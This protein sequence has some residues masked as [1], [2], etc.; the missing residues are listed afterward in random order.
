MIEG[1]W[2]QPGDFPETVSN[3]RMSVFGSGKD[4][5]DEK[6]WNVVVLEDGFPA[7]TGRI[8]WQ[9]GAFRLGCISV[10]PERRGHLLGDLVLRLLLYKAESHAAREVRLISPE[11]TVGFFERLGFKSVTSCKGGTEMLLPGDRINLDRCASCNK[12]GCPRRSI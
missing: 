5:L 6:S 8:W 9:E 7:A 4:D 12:T 10:L 1:K 2:Y 3:I 11:D